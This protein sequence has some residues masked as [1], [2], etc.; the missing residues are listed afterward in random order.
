MGKELKDN[1][2]KDNDKRKND[3]I[4]ANEGHTDRQGSSYIA[5]TR[6]NSAGDSER[7]ARIKDISERVSKEVESKVD[8]KKQ[9]AYEA[10]RVKSTQKASEDFV[11]K[12]KKSKD[13]DLNFGILLGIFGIL[14]GIF[15][16]FKNEAK[17]KAF[18]S[19]KFAKNTQDSQARNAEMTPERSQN[20]LLRGQS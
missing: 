14:L 13:T 10:E 5:D 16:V 7:G 15:V 1:E 20:D 12:P 19:K 6:D 17:L 9:R 8:L 18:F 3:T 4:S 11:K 2:L